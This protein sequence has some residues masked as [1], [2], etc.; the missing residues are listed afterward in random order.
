MHDKTTDTIQTA[1]QKALA[2]NLDELRYGTIVEIGAGQ[3]VA[4]HFFSAGAAAGTVAKT[5]SAYDMQFSDE[6][7]GKVG[8]YVSHERVEQM[9]DHEF[10]LLVSRLGESRGE[11]TTFFTYASTVAAKSFNSDSHCHG[12]VGIRF[13]LHPNAA[14]STIYF[15]VRMMDDDNQG[16]CEALG[17]MGTNI[18]HGVFNHLHDNLNAPKAFIQRLLDSLDSDR[19]EIDFIQFAGYGFEQVE[20]RLMNLYLIRSWC[21]RSVMFDAKGQSI[22]PTS[23]MRKSPIMIIRGSFKPPT[24]VHV[25]MFESG[26]NT[27]ARNSGVQPESIVSLAEITMTELGGESSDGDAE[28]LARVDLLNALGHS[29][30]ISDY[31][32]YFRLRSW[33][34]RFTSEPLALTLSVLDFH[35]LFNQAYYEGLEGGILEGMGKLFQDNTQV[36]VYPSIIDNRIVT[37]ANVEVD[38]SQRYLLKYL[39]DNNLLLDCP[40]IS[41]ENLPISAR[42][43]AEM[44]EAGKDRWQENVP[45]SVRDKIVSQNLFG[46]RAKD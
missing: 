25:D 42:R 14:H 17:V 29:V 2:I 9:L 43:T 19:L 38:S 21:T 31:F 27:F 34:R 39:V 24:K 44:I 12:H 1:A 13:Q 15:H 16:Q 45:E 10:G 18:I 28:F 41:E 37:L 40:Y 6:I 8:R 33:L 22:I 11:Q 20:N 7:Y 32:R 35:T 3:E 36:Y 5:M 4:R 26:L 46:Y 30:L 23:V